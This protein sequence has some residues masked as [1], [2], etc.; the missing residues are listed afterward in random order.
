MG[1]EA[2]GWHWRLLFGVPAFGPLEDDFQAA[3]G[4][5]EGECGGCGVGVGHPLREKVSLFF[6]FDDGL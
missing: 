3:V 4:F 1:V 6:E 5:L 2:V